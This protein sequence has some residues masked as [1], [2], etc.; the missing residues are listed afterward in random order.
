MRVSFIIMTVLNKEANNAAVIQRGP[1]ISTSSS[2]SILDPL[3][4]LSLAN[5]NRLKSDVQITQR[6]L[7]KW[8][9]QQI[10]TWGERICMPEWDVDES[11]EE[12]GNNSDFVDSDYRSMSGWKVCSSFFCSCDVHKTK[13]MCLLQMKTIYTILISYLAIY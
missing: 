13:C 3:E 2:S 12:V 6:K 1:T 7:P 4:S 8:A 10:P 9:I 5:T 11:I